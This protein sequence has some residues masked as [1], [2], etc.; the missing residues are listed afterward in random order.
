MG[1]LDKAAGRRGPCDKP[2]AR[3]MVFATMIVVLGGVVG[4]APLPAHILDSQRDPSP[5]G[6][7]GHGAPHNWQA[8][9]NHFHPH[10]KREVG[11]L[12]KLELKGKTVIVDTPV[13]E[14]PRDRAIGKRDMAKYAFPP[15]PPPPSYLA[16]HPDRSNRRGEKEDV[17]P[18]G[19]AHLSGLQ[20]QPKN[21]AGEMTS[22]PASHPAVKGG[23]P[24]E[25]SKFHQTFPPPTSKDGAARP[26]DDFRLLLAAQF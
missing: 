21:P 14:M 22:N 15:P 17:P 4:G 25:E 26:A 23:D 7:P 2:L 16:L 13:S 8:S 20:Q 18:V 1:K 24:W 6:Y 3:R 11:S 12:Q 9:P 10:E 19:T 5:I